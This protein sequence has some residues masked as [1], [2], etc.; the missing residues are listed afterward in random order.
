MKH[1]RTLLLIVL[2]T[3]NFQ[4]STSFA[5]V[6]A[7]DLILTQRNAANNNN[8]SVFVTS[9]ANRLLG[10]NAASP[11]VP[12]LIALSSNLSLSAGTLDTVQGIQTS[13]TPQ[14]ARIGIGN[15][16][17][18]TIK[19]LTNGIIKSSGGNAATNTTSGDIQATGGAGIGGSIHSGGDGVFSGDLTASGGNVG[20]GGSVNANIALGVESTALTGVSQTGINATVPFSSAATTEGYSVAV[21]TRTAAAVFTMTSGY[22]VAVLTPSLGAASAITTQRGVF[23]DNQGVS[24]V[25]NAI[26]IDIAAQSG[27]ATTNVGLRNAAQTVWTPDTR[28]GAGAV[29]V[30][31]G[32]T[33]V[34]STGVGDA[35]T[36]ANG[37]AGQ[38][39]TIVH[40]VDGGTAVL[41]PTTKT[42][43]S[44]VTFTN[45]GDTV[46]LQY[47]TT[48]G[49][50]VIGSYGVTIAP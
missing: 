1:L 34:T 39:K 43:F 49:W 38:I 3:F 18:G 19:I 25:T 20:V 11:A 21:R 12:G 15:A 33:A 17:D 47:F 45:A 37:V 24:G 36:L 42:G 27:A 40:D 5:A 16:A 50:M 6:A 31:T 2:S 7:N 30:T 32:T 9:T 44:T 14:F 46:T 26:G 41:T 48:R 29:S 23:I 8:T 28:S 22:G 13:S 10:F 35:L 4:L